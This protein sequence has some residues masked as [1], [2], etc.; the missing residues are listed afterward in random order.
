MI[1]IIVSV[2]VTTVGGIIR[3]T[4]EVVESILELFVGILWPICVCGGRG[5][6]CINTKSCVHSLSIVPRR[7]IMKLVFSANRNSV[8]K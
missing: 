6:V 2:D 1:G 4:I 3:T 8:K 7:K 5:H